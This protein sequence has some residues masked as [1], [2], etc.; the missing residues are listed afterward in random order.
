MP[1]YGPEE[2]PATLPMVPPFVVVSVPPFSFLGIGVLWP[3][4]A[5]ARV[6]S[7]RV[8]VSAALVAIIINLTMI[9][10]SILVQPCAGHGL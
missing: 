4:A 10:V 7:T 9:P 6:S 2:A 3:V 8:R 5:L 1:T